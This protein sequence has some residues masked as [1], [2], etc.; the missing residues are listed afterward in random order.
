MSG[1]MLDA[2]LVAAPR[3]WNTEYY[4]QFSTRR[5]SMRRNSRRLSVTQFSPAARMCAN[6]H[7]ISTDR[8][9]HT[10]EFGASWP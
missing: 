2:S 8:L 6:H 3:Q 9:A 5:P 1:Q 10:L 7:F 4:S